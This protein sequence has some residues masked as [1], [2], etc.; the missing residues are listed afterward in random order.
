MTL[1]EMT[2]EDK[3]L[4]VLELFAGY[5]SQAMALKR[6]G[7]KHKVVAIA[8]IDKYAIQAYMA[9]HGDTPNLGDVSKI[10]PEDVPAHD[11]IT[12]SFP[13]TDISVAGR[14]EGLAEGSGTRSSLLWECKKIIQYHKPK[15]LLMENVKNLVGKKHKEHFDKWLEYLEGLGYTNYWKVLNAKE[16]SNTPQNRER[17]FVVS[18]LDDTQGYEFPKPIPLTKKIKDILEDNVDEKYYMNKPFKIVNKG[19]KAELIM[20][21]MD[22]IKRV[23]DTDGVCPTITTMQGGNTQPKILCA[24]NINPSGKGMNGN[25]FDS[26]G[27]SPTLT[28]Q[29]RLMKVL[30]PQAT[31]TGYIEMDVPG[32]CDLSYPNSKIRR[33]RVQDNGNTSPTLT[34][35]S[36]DLCYIEYKGKVVELP[37]I[38]ASRGRNPENPTSR[39]TGLPTE[40]HLEI[41]TAGVSNTLTTVQKDNYVIC[42]ERTD[43]GLRFFKDNVSGALRTTNSCGDKRILSPEEFKIRK[44]TPKECFRLMDVSNSDIEKIQAAGI[45]NSQQYK[46]AGNSIVV[47]VLEGIFANLFKD[48]M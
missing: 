21:G 30:V 13:C 40:Q 18:I 14:Q 43:E 10:K 25:V 29:C 11:L 26:E 2:T 12:Y 22:C 35:A 32:L 3:T 37:A 16:Y 8:E 38:G 7:V 48:Y 6:L 5:G 46:M 4:R 47:G 15:Y 23:Y 36:Q 44:L 31:K 1:K 20:K 9:I 19:H 39:V 41:N 33:G 27:L 24:G 28:T 34:T 45:S 42:E 17:V